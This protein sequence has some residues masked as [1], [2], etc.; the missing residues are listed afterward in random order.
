MFLKIYAFSF[1]NRTSI[2]LI[3]LHCS[4]YVVCKNVS[5]A[6]QFVFVQTRTGCDFQFLL[7]SANI[8][9]AQCSEFY[10]IVIGS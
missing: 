5:V 9:D 4:L 3:Q 8:I 10:N 6:L 7:S 2:Q 1:A